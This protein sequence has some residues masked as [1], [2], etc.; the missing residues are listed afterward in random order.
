MSDHDPILS[1]LERLETRLAELRSTVDDLRSRLGTEA[2]TD[3]PEQPAGA[4]GH[5]LESEAPTTPTPQPAGATIEHLLETRH[6]AAQR[7]EDPPSNTPAAG[8]AR[9]QPNR[10]AAPAIEQLLGGRVFAAVG[11]LVVI[12]GLGFAARLAWNA[13]L[14]RLSDAE[15]CLATAG[16]GAVLLAAGEIVRRRLG[17]RSASGVFA[18]GLGALYTAAWAAFGLYGLIG[19]GLSLALMAAVT[20]AGLAIAVHARSVAV[21]V[22][23]LLGAYAAPVLA[24]SEDPAM[25]TLPLYLCAVTF[26]GLALSAWRERYR[27]LRAVC[28]WPLLLLGTIWMAGQYNE[29]PPLALAFAA[30]VWGLFHAE[31]VLS[32][33]RRETEAGPIDDRDADEP[34]PSLA[35]AGRS[36]ARA[37]TSS[38]STTA[39]SALWAGLA[40]GAMNTDLQ[41]MGPAGFVA[42]TALL[43]FAISGHFRWLSDAPRSER[44]RAGVALLI[45]SGGLLL[46]AVAVGLSDWTQSLVAIALACSASLIGRH[47]G[48]RGI[49]VYGAV[50]LALASL[51]VYII[52]QASASTASTQTL[53]LAGLAFTWWSA[54]AAATA[55]AWWLTAACAD[56]TTAKAKARNKAITETEPRHDRSPRPWPIALASIAALTTGMIPAHTLSQLHGSIVW[57]LAAGFAIATVSMARARGARLVIGGIIGEALIAL[58]WIGAFFGGWHEQQD[59]TVAGL[60]FG[61]L[62]AAFSIVALSLLLRAEMRSRA[63]PFRDHPTT[64]FLASAGFV[65]L[66]LIPLNT[67]AEPSSIA[68]TLIAM[69]AAAFAAWPTRPRLRLDAG[70][71]VLSVGALAVWV[72]AFVVPGWDALETVPLAHPGLWAALSLV[73][74]WS[75]AAAAP[76]LARRLIPGIDPARFTHTAEGTN[77]VLAVAATLLA[78]TATSFEIARVASATIDAQAAE[79]GALSIWW[80]IFGIGVLAIGAVRRIAP[81]RYGGLAL[82]AIATVKA[83]L[84][85]LASAGDAVRVASFIVLGVLLLGVSAGYLRVTASRRTEPA[86]PTD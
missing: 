62:A 83:V 23:A 57:W 75:A 73:A 46:A 59:V 74:V 25:W 2:T 54:L 3:A 85:D 70:A 78:L 36:F 60:A 55:A 13:G 72:I 26:A 82:L 86:P 19:P 9:R 38:V 40:F 16:V 18:A 67:H 41:W 29:M 12:A 69:T 5:P 24:R 43:A 65:T 84:F 30:A 28:W 77:A 80:G 27:V 14:L 21:A 66:A 11:A 15:K 33:R 42:A 32:I 10:I 31:L 37:I 61:P 64:P 8:T 50:T 79:R 39:W 49:V 34:A 63:E 44:E 47:I 52:D 58:A 7:S 22:L 68:W 6:D 71:L 4:T 35:P 53:E 20:I 1:R 51:R 56:S 81:A 76:D 17:H 48:S 45:M